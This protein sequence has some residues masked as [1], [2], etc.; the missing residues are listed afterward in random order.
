M[1]FINIIDSMFYFIAISMPHIKSP[2]RKSI[3]HQ[4]SSFFF[5]ND[6]TLQL[7]PMLIVIFFE[8]VKQILVRFYQ[9]MS[10]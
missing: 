7:S 9:M 6:S 2:K 5:K 8:L 3:F 1:I 4:S 10:S